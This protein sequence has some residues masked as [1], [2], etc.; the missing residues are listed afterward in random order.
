MDELRGEV[1]QHLAVAFADAAEKI[2][3]TMNVAGGVA[4]EAPVVTVSNLNRMR[5]RGGFGRLFAFVEE[6]VER[7][8]Q[9]LCEFFESGERR[10]G[11]AMFEAGNVGTLQAGAVLD[12]ALCHVFLLADGSY[13]LGK[14][15]VVPLA[16]SGFEGP[17]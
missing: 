7:D 8:F 12:V 16:N 14:N 5:E 6:L 9:G 3:E 2:G 10:N 11:A 15:H 17:W 4:V 1:H 13:S